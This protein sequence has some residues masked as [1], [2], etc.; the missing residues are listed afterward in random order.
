MNAVYRI[1]NVVVAAAFATACGLAI[2]QKSASVAGRLDEVTLAGAGA[3]GFVSFVVLAWF[4]IDK[5][6]PRAI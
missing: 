1:C 2:Y 5:H 4:V 3:L 6:S